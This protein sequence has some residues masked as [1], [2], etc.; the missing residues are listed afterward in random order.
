VEISPQ[1]GPLPTGS[2][3]WDNNNLSQK[4]ITI[5]YVADDGTFASALVVGNLLNESEFL[6][7]LIDRAR[8]PADISL[9]LDVLDPKAKRELR[10]TVQ[11]GGRDSCVPREVVLLDEA[12]GLV[13]KAAPQDACAKGTL[14]SLPAGS[15][16]QLLEMPNPT[17]P[18][19]AGLE[20]GNYQ[21]REVFW[22][23]P[24]GTVRALI[25]TGP[26]SLVPLII[27]GIAGRDVKPGPYL[28]GVTQKDA[29][30]RTSGAA[31]VEVRIRSSARA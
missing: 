18:D 29:D 24:E 30:G 14:V 12:Q 2:H 19:A 10:R 27:G 25:V 31:A 11:R 5:N 17:R 22:L 20:L 1:D 3:V 4:N 21:G 7:L 13:E 16:L 9:Y 15:R 26:G 23:K 6:E 8:V 28:I